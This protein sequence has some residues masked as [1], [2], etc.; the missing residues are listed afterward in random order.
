MQ[1]LNYIPVE[2]VMWGLSILRTVGYWVSTA[3]DVAT[4]A[5]D[6]LHR[7]FT[8]APAYLFFDAT[9]PCNV[10]SLEKAVTYASAFAKPQWVWEPRDRNFFEWS[11]SKEMALEHTEVRRPLPLLSLE[12]LD[13]DTQVVQ[14]DLTDFIE[15]ISVYTQSRAKA[16]PSMSQIIGAW[17]LGSGIVLDPHRFV[18]RYITKYAVTAEVAIETGETNAYQLDVSELYGMTEEGEADADVPEVA[19]KPAEPE[20]V[21]D[22]TPTQVEG[23]AGSPRQEA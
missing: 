18:V 21:V 15:G 20:E 6:A 19:A 22:S 8:S 12:V 2:W 14:Y 17:S 13:K 5:Y 10:Y 7:E 11:G 4:R 9:N 3:R 23:E 16:F 1:P